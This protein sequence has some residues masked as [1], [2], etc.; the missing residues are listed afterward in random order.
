MNS[1]MGTVSEIRVRCRGRPIVLYVCM[2]HTL[3]PT[4]R[5]IQYTLPFNTYLIRKTLQEICFH[6]GY[7]YSVMRSLRTTHRRY[8]S[9]QIQSYYFAKN[10]ILTWV[11]IIT[12]HTDCG[13]VFQ[14]DFYFLIT[15]I[16]RKRQLPDLFSS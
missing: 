12:Q 15:A 4:K 9:R 1:H 11:V 14:N 7:R 10:W 3:Y 6:V 5:Y 16:C 13:Q 8:Y 2:V